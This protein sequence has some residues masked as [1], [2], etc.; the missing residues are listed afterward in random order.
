MDVLYAGDSRTMINNCGVMQSFGI[1]RRSAAQPLS[2]IIG[3]Y[4][5]SYLQAM[6]KNHQVLSIAAGRT[7]I[8]RL[9]RYYADGAFSGRFEQNPLIHAKSGRPLG[10]VSR[11]IDHAVTG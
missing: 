2:A 9:M 4:G 6:D 3:T 7:S 5:A 8:A 10:A 1:A 11:L